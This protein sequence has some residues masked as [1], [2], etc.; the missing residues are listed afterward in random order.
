MKISALKWT[1][2]RRR[3]DFDFGLRGFIGI[4]CA[5]GLGRGEK[6]EGLILTEKRD[7]AWPSLPS[8]LPASRRATPAWFLPILL[9]APGKL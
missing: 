6:D 9:T 2:R 5:G 4:A 1:G 3:D 8:I 7:S